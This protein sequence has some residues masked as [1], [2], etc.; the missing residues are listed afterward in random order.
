MPEHADND[1]RLLCL[2]A[3]GYG[4]SAPSGNTGKKSPA[5]AYRQPPP[6]MLVEKAE[7]EIGHERGEPHLV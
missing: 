3:V 5:R 4:W 6:D 1:D 2:G 7:K